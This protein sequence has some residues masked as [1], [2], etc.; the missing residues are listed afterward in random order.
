MEIGRNYVSIIITIIRDITVLHNV[1]CFGY[2]IPMSQGVNKKAP[3]IVFSHL[4]SLPGFHQ[5]CLLIYKKY[6]ANPFLLSD[7]CKKQCIFKVKQCFSFNL[8][9]VSFDFAVLCMCFLGCFS[10]FCHHE[11]SY[12]VHI[13]IYA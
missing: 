10:Q 1:I 4:S 9:L 5:V 13:C 2:F 7:Y 8:L 12:L 11:T 3:Q 6:F